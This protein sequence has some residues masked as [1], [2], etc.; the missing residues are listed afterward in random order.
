[1]AQTIQINVKP[2]HWNTCWAVLSKCYSIVSMCSFIAVK[3]LPP[4]DNNF[5]D[6]AGLLER[7]NVKANLF[8]MKTTRMWKASK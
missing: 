2:E 3:D 8:N 4:T 5:S 1:M 7:A 6:I